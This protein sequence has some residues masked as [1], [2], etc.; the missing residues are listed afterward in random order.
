MSWQP[1]PLREFLLD[2]SNDFNDLDSHA[3]PSVTTFTVIYA[4]IVT[5]SFLIYLAFKY[6]AAL[7]FYRFFY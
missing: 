3:N 5:V 4:I 6:R 7:P 2:R 1:S